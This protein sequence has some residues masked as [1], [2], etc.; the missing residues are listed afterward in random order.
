V[1]FEIARRL[2]DS[3]EAVGLVGLFDTTTSPIRWP[4]RT[5]VSIVVRRVA[6]LGAA[7]RAMRFDTWAAT[8]RRLAEQLRA[9]RGNRGNAPPIAIKVAASALI[10]SARYHPGFYHG[11]LTLFSPAERESCLP[12]LESVW[13]N[14]ARTVTLVE[15]AGTHLTMLSTRHAETTG[16]CVARHLPAANAV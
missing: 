2:S 6:M 9:W 8:L 14:H 13:R 16:A 12:S 10:A 5:W 3:G 1:A 7:L 15:T 4:L 11:T